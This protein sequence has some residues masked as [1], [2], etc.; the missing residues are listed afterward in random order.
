MAIINS[1]GAL[2]V[3]S[4]LAYNQITANAAISANTE[5]TANTVV[6][7]SAVTFDGGP[8]VVEFFTSRADLQN[9]VGTALVVLLQEG[10][11]V[12]G[13]LALALATTTNSTAMPI[14]ARYRFTP[15]AGVHTYSITAYS[16]SGAATIE[17]A[18]GGSGAQV[19]AYIRIT[20]V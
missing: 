7:A 20:K 18:S 1:G 2:A 3:G 11:T 17:A 9:T 4:E 14:M 10:A 19:P 12:L 15:T 13:R 8:V 16:T 5:G 6:T